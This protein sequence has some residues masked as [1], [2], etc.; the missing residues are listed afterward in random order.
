IRLDVETELQVGELGGLM[1]ARHVIVIG[2]A[3]SAAA[4]SSAQPT[5]TPSSSAPTTVSSSSTSTTVSQTTDNPPP[6]PHCYY[7]GS[8]YGLCEDY[9]IPMPG[10]VVLFTRPDKDGIFRL[11]GPAPLQTKLAVACGDAGC[12]YNHLDWN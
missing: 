4:C 9:V 5:V 3:V 7:T 11:T 8:G 6:V 12:V 1:K 10:E 2:L